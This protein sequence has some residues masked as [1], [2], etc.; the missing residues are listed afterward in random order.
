MYFINHEMHNN[1]LKISSGFSL[2]FPYEEG[3]Q[4]DEEDEYAEYGHDHRDE[5]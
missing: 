5:V 2:P 1:S 3:S 4:A